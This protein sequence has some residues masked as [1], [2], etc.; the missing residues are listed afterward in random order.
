MIAKRKQYQRCVSC[1]RIMEVSKSGCLNHHCSPQHEAAR[2]AA[3]RR[4]EDSPH[5]PKRPLGQRL[6]EGFSM[7]RGA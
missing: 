3:N 7:L 5:P 6:G 1:G 2:A 4:G